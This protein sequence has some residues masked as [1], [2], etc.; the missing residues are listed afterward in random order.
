M[1]EQSWQVG[2][3]YGVMDNEADGGEEV[4]PQEINEAEVLREK[5]AQEDREAWGSCF[6]LL[7]LAGVSM[8]E[9]VALGVLAQYDHFWVI[10]LPVL[11]VNSVIVL[12]IM[13]KAKWLV[14]APGIKHREVP[15]W[16]DWDNR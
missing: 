14:K 5:N 2:V 8:A 3:W 6:G 12:G 10:C 7:A 15:P 1:V 11:A 13:G 16:E 4:E 9:T